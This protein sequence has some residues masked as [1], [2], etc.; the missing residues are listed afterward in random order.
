MKPLGDANAKRVDAFRL[1]GVGE[2]VGFE[3]VGAERQEHDVGLV[4]GED[5]R[6]Q[7]AA[8]ERGVARHA[9]VHD[10]RPRQPVVAQITLELRRKGLL[11]AHPEPEGDR[12]AER[13]DHRPGAR[14]RTGI[15]RPAMAV[16]VDADAPAHRLAL[17]LVDLVHHRGLAPRPERPEQLE[18]GPVEA[19][20]RPLRG[21][22]V[23]ER[24]E[25]GGLEGAAKRI[26]GRPAGPG[27]GKPQAR[28][29]FQQDQG[30]DDQKGEESELLRPARLPAGAA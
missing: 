25:P 17:H 22:I 15:G 3:V 2:A 16:V 14:L 4:L 13:R 10:P 12:I 29:A 1:L 20:A 6:Q 23:L 30:Q 26:G 7:P 21:E 18:I 11:V 8:L 5:P 28:A 24:G 27:D 9:V 19:D